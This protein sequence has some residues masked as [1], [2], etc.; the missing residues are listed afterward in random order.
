MPPNAAQC[1]PDWCTF[2]PAERILVH[3]CPQSR[4]MPIQDVHHLAPWLGAIPHLLAHARTRLESRT[5]FHHPAHR[6]LAR[7]KAAQFIKDA[8]TR[9]CTKDSRTPPHHIQV[10]HKFKVHPYPHLRTR[11]RKCPPAQV[12]SGARECPHLHFH[13]H[14]PPKC[15]QSNPAPSWARTKKK[16]RCTGTLTP[17]PARRKA[18]TNSILCPHHE[19]TMR[20]HQRVT[21]HRHHEKVHQRGHFLG[22]CKRIP[23]N[24]AQ[25]RTFQQ[26]AAAFPPTRC[27][28][29]A[30]A[31]ER[32]AGF[33]LAGAQGAAS[34][35]CTVHISS[36]RKGPVQG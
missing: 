20:P 18:R 16:E 9:W 5:T 19:C 28:K 27:T 10:P 6:V 13:V 14:I 29:E 2:A 11:I 4:R 17:A 31:R 7:T 34:S 25:G 8:R 3:K 12:S 26:G 30:G 33:F 24:L 15:P 23:T 36:N 21:V 32:L 1:R 22:R 35:R